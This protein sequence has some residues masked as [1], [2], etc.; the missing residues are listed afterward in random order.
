[1]PNTYTLIASNTVGSGGVS[2]VTFSSIPA[3]YTDL[4][5][6][7]SPRSTIAEDTFGIRFNSDSGS[8][9]PYIGF[10]GQ[11]ATVSSFNGTNTF[12]G[13]GRQSES[14]YT[15]NTFGNTEFYIP[16]YTSTNR[17]SVSVDAV[18]ESNVATGPRAQLAGALWT[19][20][21]AITSIQ[22]IP[23]A[24]SFAQYSTFTLYG[25]SNA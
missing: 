9:Y 16:N 3:T 12:V 22:V 6:K 17:K 23:S 21:V 4:I 10:V 19:G 20:V 7:A 5:L 2:S 1:M 15:A 14:G 11:G 18:N 13:L 24:G 8:N 25:I